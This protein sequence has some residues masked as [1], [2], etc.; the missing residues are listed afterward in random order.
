MAEL[1]HAVAF[2]R[3]FATIASIMPL[4]GEV[5]ERGISQEE[6]Q[7]MGRHRLLAGGH[8]VHNRTDERGRLWNL[9]P[10]ERVPRPDGKTEN[11]LPL[12]FCC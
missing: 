11:V 10:V 8:L 5:N 3:F 1:P 9:S 4:E 12:V 6:I 2:T 7:W